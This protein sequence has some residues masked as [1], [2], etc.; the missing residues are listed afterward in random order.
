MHRWNQV[1]VIPN[2]I[3]LNEFV[4][5][6]YTPAAE[7][8]AQLLRGERTLGFWGWLGNSMVDAE[9]LAYIARSRSTWG[10]NL[11][12][13]CETQLDHPNIRE[14]LQHFPNIR[15]L[16]EVPHARLKDYGRW[17]DVC[18]IPAPDNDFSRGRDPLK[19]YEYL[20]L[21]KP[22]V[23]THMPQLAGMPYVHNA[24]T[25]AEFL[26]EIELTCLTPVDAARVDEFLAQQTW[27]TRAERFLDVL[28]QTLGDRHSGSAVATVE[29][30][31]ALP[32]PNFTQESVGVKVYVTELE[33]DL[34]STRRW[35]KELEELVRIKDRE[36]AQIKA[37]PPI[38]LAL[39]IRARLRRFLSTAKLRQRVP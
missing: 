29:A 16:G 25:P 13:G 15:F 30:S 8:P 9:L 6:A 4:T 18:L 2:G 17:F 3:N 19:V 26:R 39:A 21:H 14:Q 22:V 12:G 24:S 20:A 1:C 5:E 33:T 28:S 10:I 34:E 36:L 7:Q 27:K 35:A 37:F 11:L 23:S 31:P 32:A 38:Y